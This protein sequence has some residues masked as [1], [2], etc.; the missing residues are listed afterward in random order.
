MD[1]VERILPHQPADSSDR[2]PLGRAIQEGSVFDLARAHGYTTVAFA[3]GYPATEVRIADRYEAPARGV[4]SDAFLQGF[5]DLTPLA[6]LRVAAQ[7]PNRGELHRERI[8]FTLANCATFAAENRPV[9]VFAPVVLPHPPFVFDATGGVPKGVRLEA[10]S[11]MDGS[12]LRDRFSVTPETY[13]ERYVEQVQYLNGRLLRLVDEILARATR[14]VVILIQS[15]HGPGSGLDWES[16]EK[17]DLR[18]R[19]SILS[20]YL[21]PGSDREGLHEAITPVNSFRVILGRV[22]HLDLPPLP[23][24]SYFSIWSKPYVALPLEETDRGLLRVRSGAASDIRP[25]AGLVG[26]TSGRPTPG[27]AEPE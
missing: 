21:L 19:M 2:S 25:R 27:Q 15:D 22:L 13:R 18:E 16:A 20:A 24:L 10:Y 8:E 9:F 1:F 3:S 12:H 4:A 17:S 6:Y 23:D 26:P 5:L 14:P 11:E 7:Q